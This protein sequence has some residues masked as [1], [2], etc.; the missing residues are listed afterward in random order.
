MMTNFTPGLEK[1]GKF[2]L[3]VAATVAVAAGLIGCATAGTVA[4]GENSAEVNVGPKVFQ[5]RGFVQGVKSDGTLILVRHETIEGYMPSMTMPFFVKD[6]QEVMDLREGEAI[7]FVYTING[8][9]S[10]ISNVVKI[11]PGDIHLPSP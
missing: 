2:A 11:E 6:P 9:E 5:V 1:P 8:R 7:S 10:Y 3:T 4:G